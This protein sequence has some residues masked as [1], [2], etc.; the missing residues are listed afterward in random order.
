[1]K[2]LY[3]ISGLGADERVFRYLTLPG[4]DQK[5]IKWVEPKKQE[6]LSDYCKRLIPQ[7]D[8]ERGVILVGMSFGGIVAQ[9]ISKII[10]TDK[11]I[12]ISS[13]KSEREFD[14]Q[15]NMVRVLKLYRLV[16]SPL[17]RWSNLLTG[18]YYFGT[19]S[20][21]ESD[22]LKQIIKDSDMP[23]TQWAIA[24]IMRWKNDRVTDNLIHIHGDKDRIFPIK[25]IKNTTR[26]DNGGHFMIVNKAK[27]ISALIEKEIS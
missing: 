10:K 3:Y 19:Q 24:E 9:E 25:R 16:P 21:L 15:L 1:M 6:R 27:E 5:H 12:I 23:F 4:I 14:W 13:V 26:V 17:L 20:K 2:T 11:V 7:I 18:D 22:L 8:L